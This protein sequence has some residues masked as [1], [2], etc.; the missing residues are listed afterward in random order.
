MCRRVKCEKC[1]KYTWAG[2]GQHI[3]QALAGLKPEEICNC[4]DKQKQS[5]KTAGHS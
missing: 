2:C 3:D 5:D 4:K 1:D